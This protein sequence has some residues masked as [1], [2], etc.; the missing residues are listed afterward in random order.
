MLEL[1]EESEKEHINIVKF[2]ASHKVDLLLLFGKEMEAAY[3]NNKEHKGIFWTADFDIM[4]GI[5]SKNIRPG[6]LV[7]LKGSRGMELERFVEPI[8]GLAA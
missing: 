8:K 2:A 6:D 4:L 3:E 1:G 7:L 5:I